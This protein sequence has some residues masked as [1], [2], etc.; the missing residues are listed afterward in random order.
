LARAETGDVIAAGAC[1]FPYH[2]HKPP[3]MSPP[4]SR[5]NQARLLKSHN[6]RVEAGDIAA[7]EAIIRLGM[8]AKSQSATRY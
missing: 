1:C 4:L 8:L 5:S 7:A 6:L 2:A 3:R